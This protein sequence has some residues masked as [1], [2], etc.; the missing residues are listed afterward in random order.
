MRGVP[1][2]A[3]ISRQFGPAALNVALFVLSL[4]FTL[5][6]P[7]D[8]TDQAFPDSAD[9]Q[10]QARSPIASL[11]F[12][13]PRASPG[14]YPR[15]FGVPLFYKLMGGD[16]RLVVI[17][18]KIAHSAASLI[19]A[20]S[21]LSLVQREAA[22]YLLVLGVYS[23]MSWW[24]IVGWTT[25]LLSESLSFSFL[26]CWISSVL[27]FYSRGTRFSLGLQLL[28]LSL[29]ALTRDTWPY[30]LIFFY[31]VMLVISLVFKWRSVRPTVICLGVSILL[32][33]LQDWTAR[34]G[35][36]KRLPLLNNIVLRILPN[37]NQLRWFVRRGMPQ[38]DDLSNRFEK[39]TTPQSKM[40]DLTE[41][42]T[43]G[44]YSNLF[45]WINTKGPGVYVRF[46]ISRPR[47]AFL[48]RE[49][50]DNLSRIFTYDFSLYLG[51]PK[52]YS[53]VSA[54]IFFPLFRAGGIAALLIALLITFYYQ[55]RRVLFVPH[56]IGLMT[57]FN[58]VLS[59]HADAM[60]VE[61]HL[62]ITRPMMELIGILS[63]ALLVD[64][65]MRGA[66]ERKPEV[67]ALGLIRR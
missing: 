4:T 35:E 14:F 18:Q 46:L 21:L 39:D 5:M 13:A 44:G 34:I 42:Y 16:P 25:V 67:V 17:M 41:M 7:V 27:F 33:A 19:L 9:Y 8:V 23:L 51:P 30:L 3:P 59:Y 29:L 57:V 45:S 43:D 20:G 31:G 6:T 32:F 28:S 52:G 61:R 10:H 50:R 47:T 48:L 63:L 62:V 38:A 65:V 1:V 49:S 26:F 58:A 55:R 24:T 40:D 56:L 64:G 66:P 53:R 37:E 54:A 60:E 12:F 36:R 15:P 22:K 2:L 11:E